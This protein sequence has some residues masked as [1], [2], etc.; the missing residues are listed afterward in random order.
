MWPVLVFVGIGIAIALLV[1]AY[2][3]HPALALLP[4]AGIVGIGWLVARWDQNRN[5]PPDL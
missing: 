2:T 3:V 5:A 1:V 4:V